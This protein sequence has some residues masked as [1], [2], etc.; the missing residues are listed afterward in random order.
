MMIGSSENTFTAH[1][2]PTKIPFLILFVQNQF[3]L[4]LTGDIFTKAELVPLAQ[5]LKVKDLSI[6]LFHFSK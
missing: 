4:G 2:H 3:L 5:Q 1:P 6:P